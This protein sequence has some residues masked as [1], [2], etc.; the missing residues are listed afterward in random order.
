MSE[1]QTLRARVARLERRRRWSWG[2]LGALA[3]VGLTS[4][5]SLASGSSCSE[6]LPGLL[7]PF[8]P[9][10]PAQAL[11]VNHNYRE[12]LRLI[13][14]KVGAISVA[15]GVTPGAA[16]SSAISTASLTTTGAVSAG[17][18]SAGSATVGSLNS[19]SATLGSLTVTNQSGFALSCG[20]AS[21]LNGLFGNPFCCRI[22]TSSGETTCNLATGGS[23]ASWAATA[24]GYPG[25][26]ATTAGRYALACAGGAPGANFPFCCRINANT[27][28]TTCGQGTSYSLG[29]NGPVN[30]PF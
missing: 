14:T 10:E 27:G 21:Y 20:H 30:V 23:G 13:E 16:G 24:F 9:D 5:V 11:V 26:G 6:T 2:V 4:R 1:L 12:L 25:L 8:C 22:N 15:S 7:T 29:A 18:V 28:A 19:T 3:L 17:S